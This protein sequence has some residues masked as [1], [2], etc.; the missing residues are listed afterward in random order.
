[1]TVDIN[2]AML[3][4]ARE[5]RS[6]TQK[7][8]ASAS[9]TTPPTVNKVEGGILKPSEELAQRWADILGHT[10]EF[11]TRRPDAPP[12]PM[13]FFRKRKSLSKT[14]V[15][16]IRATV[17]ICCMNLE[18][19]LQAAEIPEVNI[20]RFDIPRGDDPAR[21]DAGSPAE[22]AQYMRAYWRVPK[23][24]IANMTQLLEDNGVIV[25]RLLRQEHQLSGVSV[26]DLRSP[27]PPT[28]FLNASMPGDRSRFTL[29]HELG[30]LVLHNHLEEC[31]ESCEAE[32]DE[33]AAE[34]LT[35]AAEIRLELNVRMDL[36]D[37]AAVKRKWKVS[38]SSL[39]TSAKKVGKITDDKLL[40]L[41]KRMSFLGYHR[42]EPSQ[43]DVEPPHLLND[44]FDVHLRDFDYSA[45]QLASFIGVPVS[46]FYDEF[47]PDLR[48]PA[49][50]FG[51]LAL[52][53]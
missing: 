47:R 24:P 2:P 22:A 32:A 26:H 8:L 35:P 18:A 49:P 9:G 6:M 25:M 30:H 21:G 52:V 42:N 50:T 23:G 51:R 19:L 29:A 14:E 34:F 4:C 17:A 10:V 33:F 13:T 45:Q 37:Y 53:K 27:V 41:R 44:I 39:L 16:A 1:M 3:T 48:E 43:I 11:L 38:I 40:S 46:R 28:V 20:K 36:M 31:P 7:A 12:L 15:K 5:S